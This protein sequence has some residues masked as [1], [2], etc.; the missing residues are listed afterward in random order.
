MDE[1]R[2]T[3]DEEIKHELEKISSLETGSEEHAT[4]VESLTKLYKLKM[5]ETKTDLE[6]EDKD[7]R[8]KEWYWKCALEL[9]QTVL[10]LFVGCAFMKKGFKF[11]ETGAFTST[12]FRWLFNQFKLTKK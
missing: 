5:E 7:E 9:A 4:A 6:R 10:P 8:V 3:L 2:K 11:E 1:L 12:T